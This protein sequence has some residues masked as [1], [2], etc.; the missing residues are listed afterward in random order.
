MRV[1][2]NPDPEVITSI[3]IDEYFKIIEYNRQITNEKIQEHFF[4]CPVD[5]AATKPPTHDLHLER[6]ISQFSLKIVTK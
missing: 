1:Y 5:A 6:L 2:T 3:T 4:Q